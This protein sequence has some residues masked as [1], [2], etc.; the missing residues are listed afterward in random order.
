MSSPDINSEVSASAP[1]PLSP[2]EKKLTRLGLG[3]GIGLL[4]TLIAIN[5]LFPMKP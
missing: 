5:Q 4:L 1:E 2:M 3:L